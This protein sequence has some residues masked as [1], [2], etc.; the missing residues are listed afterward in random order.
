M[1][2]RKTGGV[3]GFSLL[4]FVLV[5]FA[6]LW[7]GNQFKGDDQ[8]LTWKQFEQTVVS[9]DVKSTIC[10][11]EDYHYEDFVKPSSELNIGDNSFNHYAYTTDVTQKDTV[12]NISVR[13]KSFF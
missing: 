11:T 9:K 6:F 1:N 10:E 13:M 8:T 3:N 4:A 5:L 7:I 12:Y 2:E